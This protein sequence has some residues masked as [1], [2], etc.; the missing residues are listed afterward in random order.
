ME[1][2]L[3]GG[4]ARETEQHEGGAHACQV[5][6]GSPQRIHPSEEEQPA[7]GRLDEVADVLLFQADRSRPLIE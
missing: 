3:G 4:E 7:E 2:V 5:M 1:Q 6:C